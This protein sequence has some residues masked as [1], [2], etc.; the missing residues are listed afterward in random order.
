MEAEMRDAISK[1]VWKAAWTTVLLAGIT[2]AYYGSWPIVRSVQKL[3]YPPM[4]AMVPAP[5]TLPGEKEP[6]RPPPPEAS[7]LKLPPKTGEKAEP[8]PV[9]TSSA[10][11]QKDLFDYGDKI[12]GWIVALAGA[13][14]LIQKAPVPVQAPPD[15]QRIVMPKRKK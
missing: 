15:E 7:A 9:M 10:P 12:V 14:K 1:A 2:L 4:V 11:P 6:A 3:T 5:A 13:Y 8:P